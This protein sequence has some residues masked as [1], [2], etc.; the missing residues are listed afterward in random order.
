MNVLL[1]LLK[2]HKELL[3]QPQP[4]LDNN[5]DERWKYFKGSSADSRVLRDVI[6]QPN[7][8]R[9]PQGYY[10]SCDAGH[11][12]G[13]GF[14]TPYRGQRSENQNTKDSKRQWTAKEDAILNKG[15]L[16]LLDDGWK[17]DAGTFK[18]GY[19][20]VLEKYLHGKNPNCTLKANP[21]IESRVKRLKSQYSAIKDMMGASGFGWDDTRKM[22]IVE[23][24]SHPTASGLYGKPFPHFENL[25]AVF[26]KD[27]AFGNAS[28]SPVEHAYNIVKEFFQSTQ[29]NEFELNLHEGEEKYDSQVPE[30]PSYKDTQAPSQVNQSQC[31]ATSNR[32]GKRAGKRVKYNGDVSDS[33]LTSLNKLGE[34]YAGSVENI[35]QLMSC[36]MHE[37]HTADRRKQIVSILKEIEGISVIDV[38]R[39]VMLIT[40]DNNLCDCFFTMD[41][42][43]LRKE[44][45]QIVLSTF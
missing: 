28:E 21:H 16:Q 38:V 30:M 41:T 44:F 13:E 4:I 33:L 17:A 9:V 25:D 37:K 26:G 7:G 42:L 20:K 11:M 10:Y 1:A 23:K 3:K 22:I 39:A 31:E 40:K 32:T 8:L 43:E 45:M 34:F 2:C 12:N 5:I 35:Q 24:E 14:L 15:L 18:P 36:F 29:G 27:K 19:T 6:S